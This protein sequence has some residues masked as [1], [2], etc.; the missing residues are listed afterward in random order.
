MISIN[1]ISFIIPHLGA[2]EDQCR[3]LN[4]CLDS[5]METTPSLK[6]IIVKNGQ[7]DC[8]CRWDIRIKEQGQCKAV[9]AGV[10]ITNTPWIMVS[11]DD[12]VY[13]PKWFGNLTENIEQ[14][15]CVSPI[16]V[17]PRKGAPT[18]EIK[19]CG[20][21]GGDFKK[22]EFFEYAINRGRFSD[23]FRNGFNLPF[24]MRREL[25][26]TVEGYDINLDPWS[27][28]SDSDLLYKI[29]LTGVQPKQN[30]NCPV[31][32]FSQTSGTFEPRNQIAWN[33]N[34][35]YFRQKWGF[36]RTDERIWEGDFSLP[37]KEQGR[38]YFPEYESKYL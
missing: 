10:A 16:L 28:N 2:T 3:A 4:I 18:F 27:S 34:W 24:L 14:L 5:L 25:W 8:N 21:A 38:I 13:P 26:N 12:M 6:I 15:V 7:Q 19:F 29:R 30:M 37:T 23:P 32:H 36:Y 33:K 22:D 1:D 9:N 11:N 17:E 31:Y 35:E 20:G